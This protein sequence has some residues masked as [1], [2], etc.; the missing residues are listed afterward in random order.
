MEKDEV[1][2]EKARKRGRI[3]KRR[4]TY[5]LKG[6]SFHSTFNDVSISHETLPKQTEDK[7]SLRE[8]VRDKEEKRVS[9]RACGRS[10]AHCLNGMR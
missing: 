6:A 10:M 5:A 2:G 7:V 9:M 4:P 1:D 3:G 8:S